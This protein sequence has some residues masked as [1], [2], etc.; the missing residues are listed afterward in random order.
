MRR[1]RIVVVGVSLLA[2]A[3]GTATA[4][5]RSTVQ[6]HWSLRTGATFQ[7]SIDGLHRSTG[8]LAIGRV[9]S[10]ADCITTATPG[11]ANTQ[12]DCDTKLPNDEPHIAVDPTDPLHMVASSNDYDSCC[13]EYYTT[14]DGGQTWHTGN[15]SVLTKRRTGSDPVTA[16][17]PKHGTVIHSSLNYVI[18]KNGQATSG[19]I[20]ASVSSDGGLTW[21]KPV[22]V[23]H[24][25]G[26]D[27]APTQVFNDKDWIVSDTN[28]ASPFYGRVY[29][30][31]SRFLSHNGHYE[32]SP[33]WESHSD[34]GGR[35]WSAGQEIS[36]SAAFCTF[37][38]LGPAGHCDEDQFSVGAVAADGT[39]YVAFENGQN[40]ANWET[41]KETESSYLVV[42]STDG[43]QTWSA[44]VDA[45]DLEDGK[46]DLPH[47]VG[48]DQTVNGYQ[49]RLNSAGDIAVAPDGTLYIVF[50]DNRTGTHDVKDPVTDLNVY[51]VTSSDG[52][53]TWSPAVGVDTGPGD[54]FFPW[55]AVN[56][57]TG[58][59][60]V[61]YNDRVAAGSHLYNA[62]LSVGLPGAFTKSIVSSA[63][64]DPTNSLF[65]QSNAPGCRKCA[66]FF[67][68]YI[69]IAYGSDGTANIAWTDMS[70][71]T[72]RFQGKPLPHP[73]N[74]QFIF[75][76]R[77]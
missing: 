70:V 18:L 35:T 59:L 68:D 16:F 31:W 47:S 23:Y 27:K 30:T 14:F 75:F 52:G 34:D 22:V 15:M 48:G 26:A 71:V 36:G 64:S 33:I 32:E 61:L 1:A 9:P 25:H 72:D 45:A 66:T 2:L 50:A 11:A 42:K 76:A 38:T 19:D 65:F 7:R 10:A 29:V 5:A 41:G 44:P 43:G 46:H 60:G 56:P 55:A 69:S 13:D 39:L 63:P 24:G 77:S 49:V 37:Q 28:P 74:L 73:R 6:G 53:A 58:Q 20:V 12:L 17:D 57:A 54:Q 4:G 3:M 40:S 62:S 8:S 67:G 51:V 21:D